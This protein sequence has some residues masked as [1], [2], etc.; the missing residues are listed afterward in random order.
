MKTSGCGVCPLQGHLP[1]S[2]Y[3]ADDRSSLIEMVKFSKGE[4][5][6]RKIEE[7]EIVFV[8]SGKIHL[9]R[10]GFVKQIIPKNNFFLL[11]PGCSITIEGLAGSRLA[12]CKMTPEVNRC[13]ELQMPDFVNFAPKDKG[14][15]Y[16]LPF[17]IHIKRYTRN[18]IE[19][20]ELGL[21]CKTYLLSKLSE[22]MFLLRAFY[23]RRELAAFFLQTLGKDFTFR[24][25][26]LRMIGDQDNINISV[27]AS[28]CGMSEAG[29]RHKFK[30][31][32]GVSPKEY[33]QKRKKIMILNELQSGVKTNRQICEEYGFTH[34]STFSNF[35]MKY[36]GGYP[37]DLRKK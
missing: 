14:T 11:S 5:Y 4:E 25:E 37:N 15:L 8:L 16:A 31:E 36:L 1:C 19:C 17:N 6:H 2:L 35:C 9:S 21:Q 10:R 12:F 18:L 20:V 22:L 33:L 3:P 32:F 7:F 28:I 24:T 23:T 26:M 13:S 27:M 29:F 30:A 34:P